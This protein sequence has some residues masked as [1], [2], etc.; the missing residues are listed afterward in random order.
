MNHLSLL[1]WVFL[2]TK[3]LFLFGR[4]YSF[5]FASLLSN[6]ICLQYHTEISIFVYDIKW[7]IPADPQS[8]VILKSCKQILFYIFILYQKCGALSDCYV[9]D[10]CINVSTLICI[11]LPQ[12]DFL[13]TSASVVF[14]VS[15][16]QMMLI[17]VLLLI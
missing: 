9:L 10:V 5:I 14:V 16:L 15:S 17:F 8:N 7:F 11:Y 6:F 2:V 12:L 4:S 1:F 13:K 3:L